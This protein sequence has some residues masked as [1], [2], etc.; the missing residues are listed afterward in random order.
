MLVFIDPGRYS[1]AVLVNNAGSVGHVSFANDLPSL[2]KLRSEMDFN[3][4]SAIWLSSRFSAIFGAH[5]ASQPDLVPSCETVV[6]ND[7]PHVSGN[8][9]INISSLAALQPFESWS[10]YSAGKACREMF[11]RYLLDTNSLLP[12]IALSLVLSYFTQPQHAHRCSYDYIYYL[13]PYFDREAIMS[14]RVEKTKSSGNIFGDQRCFICLPHVEVI[15]R[16]L[17]RSEI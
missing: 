2:A 12:V 1:R 3:A 11:H 9:V 15:S 13:Y 6:M 7:A 10:G 14:N 5:K 4:T 16:F 8:I 17:C